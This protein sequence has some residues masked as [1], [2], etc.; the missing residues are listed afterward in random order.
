VLPTK[1]KCLC[2]FYLL[3]LKGFLTEFLL[4]YR[5]KN[6]RNRT[7][8]FIDAIRRTMGVHCVVL[9]GYKAVDDAAVRS[10]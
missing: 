3:F 2:E 5:K 8:K 4:S 1:T 9:A 10:L 7:V 6:L